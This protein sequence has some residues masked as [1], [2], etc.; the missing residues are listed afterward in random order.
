MGLGRGDWLGAASVELLLGVLVEDVAVVGVVIVVLLQEVGVLEVLPRLH[1]HL[2]LCH[3]LVPVLLLVA[4]SR[5]NWLMGPFLSGEIIFL[6]EAHQM[7]LPFIS[8]PVFVLL[9]SGLHLYLGVHITL[10]D[11]YP[12]IPILGWQVLPTIVIIMKC[13]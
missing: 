10:V 5:I 8:L 3:L 13:T 4:V 6:S 12:S 9:T 2:L 1:H 11:P 7:L